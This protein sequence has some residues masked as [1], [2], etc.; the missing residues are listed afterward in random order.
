M[1]SRFAW[2]EAEREI[3]KITLQKRAVER[4]FSITDEIPL[5]PRRHLGLYPIHFPVALIISFSTHCFH[6]ARG[7]PLPTKHVIS[8]SDT[9]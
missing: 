3:Q 4:H 5:T 9:F 1:T 6:T 2:S 7:R 8:T